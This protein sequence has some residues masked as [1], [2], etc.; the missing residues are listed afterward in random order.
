MYFCAMHKAWDELTQDDLPT[1]DLRRIA[2]KHGFEVAKDIWKLCRG[3]SFSL[4]VRF[5][6]D[7]CIRYIRKYWDGH[8]VIHLARE[9]GITDRCVYNYINHGMPDIPSDKSQ[10]S[11]GL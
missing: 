5:S 9:L 3:T 8:N 6:R 4:P 1:D 10:L 2:K 11:M 7:F